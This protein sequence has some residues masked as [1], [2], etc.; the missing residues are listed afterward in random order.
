V[1]PLFIIIT[2]ERVTTKQENSESKFSLLCRL[3]QRFFNEQSRVVFE[4]LIRSNILCL[5]QLK[6]EFVF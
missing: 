2:L 4:L 1:I 5:V 6:R 3:E